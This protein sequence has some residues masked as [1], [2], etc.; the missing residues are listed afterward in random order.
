MTDS[1][2]EADEILQDLREEVVEAA[3]NAREKAGERNLEQA[4]ASAHGEA[5]AYEVVLQMI[6]SQLY[7]DGND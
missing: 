6:D 2:T 4:R 7:G 1:A 5:D 3:D